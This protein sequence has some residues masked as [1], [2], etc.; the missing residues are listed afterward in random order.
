MANFIFS[1]QLS[2]THF[3]DL[4]KTLTFI[5]TSGIVSQEPGV[6]H[7]HTPL[8]VTYQKVHFPLLKQ[9]KF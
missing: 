9:D 4:S 5:L 8:N 1:L 7:G 2:E 3:I 6:N